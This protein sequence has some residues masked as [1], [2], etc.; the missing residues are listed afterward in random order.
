MVCRAEGL[1]K[2]TKIISSLG[3]FVK[4]FAAKEKLAMFSG[5]HP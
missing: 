2:R 1:C 5:D 3:L 4:E